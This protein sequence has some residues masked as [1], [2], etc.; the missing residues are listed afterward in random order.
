MTARLV[1]GPE[2]RVE[3]GGGPA[4]C[5]VRGSLDGLLK[6]ALG[7]GAVGAWIRGRV[8]FRGNPF[9]ALALLRLCRS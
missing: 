2:P 3:S 1:G 6:V 4:D 7:E 9:G 8:S 5:A